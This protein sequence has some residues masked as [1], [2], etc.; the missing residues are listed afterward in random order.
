M[1]D[2]SYIKNNQLR[3]D[4]KQQQK[5]R[6]K[7]SMKFG[8]IVSMI[9]FVGLFFYGFTFQA[10]AVTGGIILLLWFVIAAATGNSTQDAIKLSG[11]QGEDEA[12]YILRNLPADY[13]IFN[14]VNLPDNRSST[15]YSEAD[16]IIHSPKATFV[17]E[18]KHNSGNIFIDPAADSWQI[19]KTGRKGGQYEASMRNPLKQ[20]YKQRI[21]LINYFKQ[22]HCFSPIQNI[23]LLS[24]PSASVIGDVPQNAIICTQSDILHTIQNHQPKHQVKN[25]AKVLSSIAKLVN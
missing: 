15:G 19:I 11:A 5:T 14:Q 24:N 7:Q 4:V 6:F 13:T 1:A 20:S 22:E 17:V 9:A 23:V 16:F 3:S 21:L 18:V 8:F 25:H 10:S 12:L 2:L